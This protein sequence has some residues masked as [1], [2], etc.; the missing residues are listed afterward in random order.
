VGVVFIIFVYQYYRSSTFTCSS[1]MDINNMSKSVKLVGPIMGIDPSLTGFAIYVT[2]IVGEPDYEVTFS[3]K[4]VKNLAD[5]VKRVRYLADNAAQIAEKYSPA[6]CLIEGYAY[7]GK[8]RAGLSLAELGMLTRDRVIDKVGALVEIPPTVLKKFVTGKGNSNK[9]AVSTAL[10][11]RFQRTFKSDDQAD[12]FGLAQLGRVTLKV[13]EADTKFQR[14]S[15]KLVK[16]LIEN[17]I[18]GELNQ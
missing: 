4:A 1:F 11:M 10:T 9:I 5:R 18:G 7:G 2:N 16:E 6:L 12:A 8:G 3:T 15:A 14:E 17:E 13:L